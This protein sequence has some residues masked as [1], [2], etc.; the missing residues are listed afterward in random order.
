MKAVIAVLVAMLWISSVSAATD[1]RQFDSPEQEQQYRTLIASLR[2]PKC[3]NTSIADSNAMI[4]A[5]MRQKV[6]ELLGQ[7]Q[8]PQQIRDYMVARY[9]YFVS[10]QPPVTPL[11]LFLWIGPLLFLLAGG[12]VVIVRGRCFSPASAGCLNTEQQS[13]LARLLKDNRKS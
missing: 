1:V 2:C 8:N 13:R 7:G 3:Q 12:L 10:Y 9:G 11:T 4:A 6:Y 5:D